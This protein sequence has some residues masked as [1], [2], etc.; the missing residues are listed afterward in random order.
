MLLV[1][2]DGE[3][4]RWRV[5]IVMRGSECGMSAIDAGCTG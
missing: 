1:K 5:Q 4:V 3:D 2:A